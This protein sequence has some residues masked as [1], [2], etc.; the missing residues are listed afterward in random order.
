[1]A[2][3]YRVGLSFPGDL[4]DGLVSQVAQILALKFARSHTQDGREFVLYDKF[5]ED[6]F[7]QPGL[8]DELPNL[9]RDHCEVIA[10]FLC[11][12]YA[13]RHWCGL[14][15]EKIKQLAADPAGRR[16]IY[17]IWSGLQDDTILEALGLDRK[18]D[19]FREFIQPAPPDVAEGIWRRLRSL[20]PEI[21]HSDSPIAD[22]IRMP[23]GKPQIS[24]SMREPIKRL[25][26]VL[27]PPGHGTSSGYGEADRFELGFYIR[28]EACE[29][30]KPFHGMKVPCEFVERKT[31]YREWAEIAQAL[32]FWA[33]ESAIGDARPIVE[34]FLPCQL[35]CE[36]VARDFL[37]V[38]CP[39]DPEDKFLGEANFASMCPTVV[40][41]LDRYLRESLK[42]HIPHLKNKLSML[43]ARK[44]KWIYDVAAASSDSLIARRDFPEDVA[45]RMVS[46]LPSEAMDEWLIKMIA[47]M[48]PFALWW[49]VPGLNNREKHLLEYKSDERSLLAIGE[50]GEV[51][52]EPSDLDLLPLLR[53]RLTATAS[54]L[55]LM[56]DNPDHIPDLPAS[57]SDSS[58]STPY[59]T[60]RS[61]E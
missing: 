50:H 37:N 12:E 31:A 45:V 61:I 35:L 22:D 6:Q 39:V 7:N 9:Y 8:S 38:R 30:Y 27:W 3:R 17:L 25:A 51:L 18:V 40:R 20:V 46:D 33:S 2:R 56:I 5:H 60:V 1:M 13:S 29:T 54:S 48:V 36:L 43:S 41:P 42:N 24:P 55:V 53:K 34:L 32:A 59:S 57:P 44:G 11:A 49:A 28:T 19:G 21:A 16:R 14:E 26:L 4:R 52:M 58:P 23:A 47:S 10:V 15:W